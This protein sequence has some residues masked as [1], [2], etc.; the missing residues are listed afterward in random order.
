VVVDPRVL[1]AHRFDASIIGVWRR[2]FVYGQG[3]AERW[4]KKSGLPELPVV[5]ALAVVFACIVVPFSWPIGAVLGVGILSIPTVVWASRRETRPHPD[6]VAYPFASLTDDAAKIMGF[7]HGVLHK[8]AFRAGRKLALSL[9]IA[10]ALF[11]FTPI[12]HALLTLVNGS[13]SPAPYTSLAL[14]TPSQAAT[15]VKRGGVVRLRLTNHSGRDRTYR[16]KATQA[17]TLV[18]TGQERVAKGRTETI[19]VPTK[20]AVSGTLRV[21]LDGT[22]IFVAFPVV[23][24]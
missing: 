15:G 5:G 13:F 4:T 20:F 1:M 14:R 11:G 2:S 10:V 21:S 22:N 19:F 16:W 9:A 18:G 12:S 17:T 3:V 6:V 24:S 23:K 7:V 8:S